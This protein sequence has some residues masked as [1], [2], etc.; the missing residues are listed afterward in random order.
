MDKK[1]M[2][3]FLNRIT[4][5]R[6]VNLHLADVPEPVDQA[7]DIDAEKKSF[8]PGK[9]IFEEIWDGKYTN[10]YCIDVNIGSITKDN[11]DEKAMGKKLADI[12]NR[13]MAKK[14]FPHWIRESLSIE[15]ALEQFDKRLDRAAIIIF[16]Y[17]QNP[18]DKK[19]KDILTSLRKFIDKNNPLYV[20]I[21]IISSKK[22]ENWDLSPY[23]FLDE[24]FLEYISW[25]DLQ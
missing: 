24:R 21:L 18:K 20:Q 17:F 3:K 6:F 12:I 11:K 8:D 1:K 16:H 23:S 14:R 22:T 19:E 2:R 7:G 10:N 5:S 15:D 4:N 9:D 13:E 25:K